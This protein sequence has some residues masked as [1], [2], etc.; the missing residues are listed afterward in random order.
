MKP[1]K[2]EWIDRVLA[3][4]E[5]VAR[6]KAPAGFYAN[7]LKRVNAVESIS[8]SYVLRIAAGVVLL[9]ALNAFVCTTF[10]KYKGANDNTNLQAFAREYAIAP[11]N[12][13]F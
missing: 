6:A 8:V 4:T 13:N 2:E 10:S 1:D 11:G 7:V 9:V 3:S 5:G 12:D